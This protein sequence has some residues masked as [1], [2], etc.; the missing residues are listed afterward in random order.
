MNA[1]D[2]TTNRTLSG[3][4][5]INLC[6]LLL[7]GTIATGRTQ[8]VEVPT[9]RVNVTTR[10]DAVGGAHVETT[11]RFEP[12]KMYDTVKASMPNLFVLFRDVIGN[13]RSAMEVDR[14]S[15]K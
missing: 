4:H 10:L 12:A 3:I 2:K 13:Y 5:A 8:Q 1:S 14:D 7:W 11:T 6:W 9:I 15:V